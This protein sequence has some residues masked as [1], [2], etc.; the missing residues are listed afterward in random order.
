MGN[1]HYKK[2]KNETKGVNPNHSNFVSFDEHLK[3]QN[4]ETLPSGLKLITCELPQEVR[5]S[6]VF[7]IPVLFNL[8]QWNP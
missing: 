4:F 1:L 3:N 8:K 5:R 2:K 7:G 6:N